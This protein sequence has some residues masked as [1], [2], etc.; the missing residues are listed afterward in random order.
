[1]AKR[2]TKAQREEEQRAALFR[3]IADIYCGVIGESQHNLDEDDI[4]WL[5]VD[6]YAKVHRAISEAFGWKREHLRGPHC[7]ENFKTAR[8]LTDWLFD[9]GYRADSFFEK[10]KEQCS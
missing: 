4:V 6:G 1:M 7:A 2:K 8:T 10:K 9:N 5:D 3:R